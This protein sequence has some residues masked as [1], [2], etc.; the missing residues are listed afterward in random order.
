MSEVL[1][2]EIPGDQIC[3]NSI[4]NV[5]KAPSSSFSLNQTEGFLVRLSRT[6]KVVRAHKVSSWC[7]YFHTEGIHSRTQ[8]EFRMV[9]TI[10]CLLDRAS[11]LI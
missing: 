8:K 11:T 4:F 9:A 1:L 6:S 7:V 5:K 10:H 2:D 3:K